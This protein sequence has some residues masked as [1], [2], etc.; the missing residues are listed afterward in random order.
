MSRNSLICKFRAW[1]PS[2]VVVLV[3]PRYAVRVPSRMLLAMRL[4]LCT[5]YVLSG[6]LGALRPEER[7]RGACERLALGEKHGDVQ[8]VGDN[9]QRRVRDGPMHLDCQFDRVE[10]IAV[11]R[12]DERSRRDGGEALGREVHVGRVLGEACGQPPEPRDLLIGRGVLAKQTPQS[13]ANQRARF[14]RSRP[15]TDDSEAGEPLGA[16]CFGR[17]SCDQQPCPRL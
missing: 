10:R 4:I 9:P 1:L 3:R 13:P 7:H 17:K 11:A 16:S 6:R 12:D 14:V 2:P 8:P 15:A 5:V